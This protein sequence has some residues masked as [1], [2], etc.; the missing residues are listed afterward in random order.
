[1]RQLL[2]QAQTFR[3]NLLQSLS[4]SLMEGK[5]ESMSVRE[6][7]RRA[8]EAMR[9][10]EEV[11]R[12][13][14]SRMQQAVRQ[15]N[16]VDHRAEEVRRRIEVGDVQPRPLP[17]LRADSLPSAPSMPSMP[18]TE[19]IKSMKSAELMDKTKSSVDYSNDY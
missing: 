3:E 8:R 14:D 6:Q 19:S 7:E 13:I 16:E 18:S 1:M 11:K 10:S 17:S 9:R 15:A 4:S 2:G 5:R 12:R